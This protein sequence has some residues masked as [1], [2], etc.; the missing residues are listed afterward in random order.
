LT[1][2]VHKAFVCNVTNTQKG[3]NFPQNKIIHAYT[4]DLSL[5]SNNLKAN[6]GQY[7]D[8]RS[9]GCNI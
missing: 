3:K 5:L 4:Q 2:D 7:L 9:L 1:V 6:E 8:K